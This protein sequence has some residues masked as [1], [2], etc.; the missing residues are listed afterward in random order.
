MAWDFFQINFSFI[1]DVAF[2]TADDDGD[3]YHY[4]GGA[5]GCFTPFSDVFTFCHFLVVFSFF[6]FFTFAHLSFHNVIYLSV[7]FATKILLKKKW[8][9]FL[10]NVLPIPRV[11]VYLCVCSW[12]PGIWFSIFWYSAQSVHHQM[13]ASSP[14]HKAWLCCRKSAHIHPHPQTHTHIWTGPTTVV[15]DVCLWQETEMKQKYC[16][17]LNNLTTVTLN[18]QAGCP[19]YL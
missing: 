14:C 19:A 3:V 18:R 11:C 17:H 1:Y 6:C 12:V 2:F 13:L 4:S 15:E 9:V 16:S 7:N 10:E 8:M 5:S